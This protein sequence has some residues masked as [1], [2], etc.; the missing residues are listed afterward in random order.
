MSCVMLLF[1]V[2]FIAGFLPF[3]AHSRRGTMHFNDMKMMWWKSIIHSGYTIK[4]TNTLKQNDE[5][6]QVYL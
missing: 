3:V 6:C 2:I 5:K 4:P 1:H